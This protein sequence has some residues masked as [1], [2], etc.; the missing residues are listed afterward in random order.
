MQMNR[1]LQREQT[2][3]R[4]Q[5]SKKCPNVDFKEGD[6]AMTE[7]EA[8]DYLFQHWDEIIKE[9]SDTGESLN[10]ILSRYTGI[11]SKTAAKLIDSAWLTYQ[12][13]KRGL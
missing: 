12:V 3:K 6:L 7:K 5:R 2:S 1:V 11:D 8:D 10:I 9:A 13:C 4:T